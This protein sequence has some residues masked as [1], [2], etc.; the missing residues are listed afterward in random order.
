V[1]KVNVNLYEE[2]TPESVYAHFLQAWQDRDFEGMLDYCQKYWV[3]GN[4]DPLNEI[5]V[6]FEPFFIDCVLYIQ[7]SERNDTNGLN[8]DIVRD[9]LALI[10]INYEGKKLKKK[11]VPRLIKENDSCCPSVSGTWGVNP[12]SALRTLTLKKEPKNGSHKF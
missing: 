10:E 12:V 5:K 7:D 6:R 1:K 4:S 9:L 11:F 8:T 3:E 2:G